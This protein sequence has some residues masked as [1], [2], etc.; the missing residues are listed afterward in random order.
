MRKI[1]LTVVASSAA[2]G[3]VVTPKPFTAEEIQLQAEDRLGA[4]VS[5]QTAVSEP[6]TL[7]DA[8]ARA[9]KYNLDLKVELMEAALRSRELKLAQYDLLPDLVANAG[10][11]GR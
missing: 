8:M 6:I 2:A 5:G 9:I 1:I 7:Y 11:A 4:F 10:Y 3:C